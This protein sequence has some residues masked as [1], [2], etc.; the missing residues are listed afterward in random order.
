MKTL[1]ISL[2]ILACLNSAHASGTPPSE[3]SVE[4]A[5]STWQAMTPEQQAA[6]QSMMKENAQERKAAWGALSEEDKAA[7]RAAMKE[8][9][10]PYRAKM[11]ARMA[12]RPFGRQ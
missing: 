4:Q 1:T 6:A 3:P 8:M 9:L 11:Q 5:R 12:S 2:L 7:K 10:Q